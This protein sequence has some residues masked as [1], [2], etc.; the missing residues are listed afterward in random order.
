M[1]QPSSVGNETE[2]KGHSPPQLPVYDE[3]AVM[4]ERT[5][6]DETTPMRPLSLEASASTQSIE[7]QERK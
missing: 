3:A 2:Q 4:A 7:M 5:G 1:S 6:A